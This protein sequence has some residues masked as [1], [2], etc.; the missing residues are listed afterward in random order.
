MLEKLN[1]NDVWPTWDESALTADTVEVVVQ[2]NGKL[3]ARLDVSVDDADDPAKLEELAKADPNVQKYLNG[4]EIRKVI[5][6]KNTKLVNI[7][8]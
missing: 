8:V 3:R 7:V 4:Q 6:P 2:V 5:T 1:T